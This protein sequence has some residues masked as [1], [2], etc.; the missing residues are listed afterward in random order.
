MVKIL[1][2]TLREGEQTP[3][4]CFD[5]HIKTAIADLLDQVGVDII[6]TGHPAVTAE[7]RQSVE[8]I[9]NRGLNAIIGAHSRSLEADVD[10]A[11]QCGVNFLGIF[12]CV[13][14]ERLNHHSKDLKEAVS[15]IARVIAYA[16]EK[17][18]DL[19]IRYTPEDTV[20][21]SWDNVITAASEAV[22]AGAD[23]IS[24]ADTTGFMIPGTQRSMR[25]YVK[26]LKET[27]ASQDL[28][29]QIAVHCHNDR[30]L[31]VANALDGYYGGAHII[32]ATVL[33]LGERAGLADLATLLAIFS[34]DFDEN[35]SRHWNLQKLPELY[36]IVSRYANVPVPVNFPL[37]GQNAFTHCAGVHTQAA[38]K[39]PLHYQSIAPELVG[40]QSHI[41]LDHMSGMSAVKHSL[42]AIGETAPDEELAAAVLSKVKE[43]GQTGRIVDLV[44]LRYIVNFLKTHVKSHTKTIR[45]AEAIKP[46]AALRGTSAQTILKS[47]PQ[48]LSFAK[49]V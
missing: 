10:L 4:V 47:A 22:R 20:R 37:M 2:T 28:Y 39:D 26:K 42:A 14:E 32:D 9:A 48:T 19:L 46:P 5:P 12:Y 13:S 38:L 49:Q 23:I 44:E 8:E 45:N 29:P 31:A 3:G 17:R 30:G 6:E 16:K 11:L 15:R 21:S 43:V 1:D 27:L 41:S 7:V 34:S 25:D 36:N 33:G 18:P 24:I 40:R 35:H